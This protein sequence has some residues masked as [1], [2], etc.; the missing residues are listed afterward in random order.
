MTQVKWLRFVRMP[1]LGRNMACAIFMMAWPA[2]G[3]YSGTGMVD[4][5]EASAGLAFSESE[6][7]EASAVARQHFLAD[8]DANAQR[9]CVLHCAQIARV[10]GRLLAVVQA[11]QAH[12]QARPQ[13]EIVRSSALDAISF[14]QGSIVL[15]E[16][17]VS[18][19]ELEDAELAFVLAHE[20]A[21]ILLQHERQTLTSAMALMPGPG[22]RSAT[23]CYAQIEQHYFQ[24]DDYFALIAQQTEFEADETGFN[25]AALAGFDPQRQMGFMRKLAH[26]TPGQSMLSSHPDA[27]AR[28][29][30]L[31]ALLPLAARLYGLD[32]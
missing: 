3:A 25:M 32:K 13:L 12:T 18:R 14:A 5:V 19:L 31:Q 23:D 16:A 10:W 30:R 7:G 15:S 9:G 22:P 26:V 4:L 24:M 27:L 20:A 1:V 2:L 29:E 11:Q 17:F 6:V 8:L 21:H 28:L